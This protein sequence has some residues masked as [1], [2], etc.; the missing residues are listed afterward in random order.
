[1]P[2]AGRNRGRMG[3]GGSVTPMQVV[4][5]VDRCPDLG[6]SVVTIGAYDGVHLGHRAVIGQVRRLA[7]ERGLASVVVTFDRHPASVVRPDSAPL[8]LTDLDQKLELLEETGVDVAMVVHFDDVRAKEPAEDF[9]ADLLVGCLAA[10]VVVVGEDFHFGHQRRGNVELLR[11][12]GPREGFEVAPVHLVGLDGAAAP[13]GELKV[14][15]TAIRAALRSGDLDG[16]NAMLGRHHEVRGVVGHGDERARQ[17][18]FPTANVE[19]PDEVCLPA[20][21]IY[22]AWYVRPDGPPRPAAVSLG[23]RPTF[24][25]D[26]PYSLLEAHLLDVDD[27]TTLDLYGEVARVRFVQ[28]LRDEERFDSVDDLV[29]QMGRDCDRARQL[30]APA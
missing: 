15:S 20:D 13:A 29:D 3:R 24:Y 11:E 26:Q 27:P 19:V 5:S 30:L 8:V 2:R 14:S 16:A 28:R 4:H 10:R 1:M 22:A 23:R 7:G 6:G 25:D 9:V 12:L 18:G 21:G 17:L